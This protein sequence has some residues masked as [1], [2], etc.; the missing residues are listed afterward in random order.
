MIA[1]EPD[2]EIEH[3]ALGQRI[4][5]CRRFVRDQKLRLQQHHRG[6]HDALTHAAGEF[7]RIGVKSPLGIADL[8]ACEHVEAAAA[9]LAL[10]EPLVQ[11][12]PLRHL[13]A[14]ADGRD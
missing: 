5:R 2:H 8:Y 1:G 7:V 4:Q 9:D 12:E 6:Q 14:D 10:A 3:L 11:A 13:C